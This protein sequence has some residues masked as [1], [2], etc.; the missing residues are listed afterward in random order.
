MDQMRVVLIWVFFLTYAGVGH[1]TFSQ[2]KLAGFTMIIL[3]VLVFNKILNLDCWAKASQSELPNRPDT[4]KA[5]RD[6]EGEHQ[7]LLY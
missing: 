3:G 5:S 7:A 6:S 2:F 1:E 4:E